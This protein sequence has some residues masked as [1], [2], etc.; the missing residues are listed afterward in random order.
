MMRTSKLKLSC[1]S[2]LSN[3]LEHI[4]NGLKQLHKLGEAVI[5]ELALA[6]KVMVVGWDKLAE[7]HTEVGLVPQQIHNLLSKLLGALH[8]LRC[9]L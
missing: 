3:Y 7:G 9:P 5:C 1:D 2:R 4:W 6:A 8:L